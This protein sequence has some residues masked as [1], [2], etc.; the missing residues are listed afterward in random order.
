MSTGQMCSTPCETCKKE[1]L[2]LLLARYAVHTSETKAPTL[3]GKLGGA[4]LDAIPLGSHAQY[5]LRL[6]RSGYV[7]VFDEARKHWDEY[8]VTSDGFLTKLPPRPKTGTRAAPATNFACARSGAAPLAGVITIRNPKHATHIW[9]GFS[10]VEWTDETLGKHG[11]A[12]YRQRHMQKVTVS[13]GKVPP[14]AHTTPLENIDAVVPEFKLDA[15]MIKKQ[16]APWSPFPFNSRVAT[17]EDFKAAVHKARPQGGAAV[18]ALFDPVAITAEIDALMTFRFKAFSV[19]PKRQ[20]PLAVS[21]AIIQL[22]E[23]VR[24]Q[25]VEREEAAAEELAN[26]MF[27]QPDIGVLFSKDYRERKSKQIEDMRTV[28]PAEAKRA[29]EQAWAKYTAKFNEPAMRQWR[30]QYE[31]DLKAFDTEQIAPLAQAH[32]DWMKCGVT[33]HYFACNFDEK[34][35]DNGAAYVLTLSICIGNSQDKAACFDLYKEWLGAD[36]FEQCNLL[37]NA[38]ALNLDVAKKRIQESANVSLDW[39]GFS[40][41]ALSGA[42]GET[43]KGQLEKALEVLGTQLVVRTM[44]PLATVANASASVGRAK[45]SLVSLSVWAGKPYTVID[46]VGGKKAFRKVLI[47]HLVKLSKQ[48]MNAKQLQRAVS[49]EM[50][51][52]QIAGVKLDGTA[53]K[54]FLIFLD[55]NEIAAMPKNLDAAGKAQWAASKL[56]KVEDIEALAM[57]RWQTKVANVGGGMVRGGHPYLVGL[58][59]AIFQYYAL[60]KLTEDNE[61]VMSHETEESMRRMHAG[62]AAFWGTVADVAGQGLQKVSVFV[63]KVARGLEVLGRVLSFVGR[64]AGIAGAGIVAYWDG[65]QGFKALGEG[66]TGLGVLYLSSAV[67]GLGAAG[68]MFVASFF[69]IA[70]A[71]PVAWILIALLIAVAV[72]IEFFKDNKIQ[73]WLKRCWWGNGPDARYPDVETELAQLKQALA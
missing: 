59:G 29:E 48:P 15:N 5:G 43:Y 66:K 30:N 65:K 17:V 45:L 14:Q 18:V 13:N 34:N 4:A 7:Y 23:A 20:R 44:G 36:K 70:W 26:D 2:P 52:L 50:R 3:T 8:F 38:Y 16:I 61:K 40:W 42:I 22:E 10:D 28:T 62:V 54:R 1:G 19:D 41:D 56:K 68:L 49:A 21:Q 58:I 11:D 57:E 25:A 55:D 63:P 39:R 24:A 53:K 64:V 32:R 47:R 31:V 71:G 12:A 27:A 60:A 72:L 69:S 9:I 6:L 37:L 33:T 51:R 67:L 73:E 46:V 35:V